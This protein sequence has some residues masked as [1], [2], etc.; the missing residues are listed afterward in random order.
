MKVH[1]RIEASETQYHIIIQS[2]VLLSEFSAFKL[3]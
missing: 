2:A 3:E 1:V